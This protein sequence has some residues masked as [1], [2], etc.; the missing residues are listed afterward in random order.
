VEAAGSIAC[1]VTKRAKP[2]RT[3][4]VLGIGLA[5]LG[6]ILYSAST[7]DRRPPTVL[8]TTLTQHLSGDP[9]MALTTSSI[10]V[11]FSEPID[12]PTG[13]AAFE[14][15][16]RVTGS[17]SWSAARLI[18]TPAARLPLKTDFV[19]SIGPGVRD[20]A[21]NL[22]ATGRAPFE[23]TTVGNPLVLKSD[24]ANNVDDVPL[25][26][27]ITIDF[28]T[29]MD[30]PSVERALSLTPD[31]AVA[32][33]W[34]RERLTIVPAAPL[35]PNRRYTLTIGIGAHDQA[36]TPLE[37]QFQLTFRTVP[38]GLTARGLIPADGVAGIAVTTPIAVVL[39]RAI[40]PSSVRDDLLTITPA[41][42]GSLAAIA[43][44]G[45]AG[46]SDGSVHVLRFQPSGPLDPNTTY[47]VALKPGLL[48]TDGAAMPAGLSWTF[49]TGAPTGT[50]SNQ[51]VFVSDR[52]GI[53]NLWAMNPDGTNQRQLS[54]ELSPVVDY[55][56]A[57]DGRAFLVADGATIIWERAD[58]SA[59]RLLTDT[60]V[61]EFDPAF[62]PDGSSITFGRADPVLGGGLGLWSRDADGSDPRRVELPKGAEPTPSAGQAAPQPLLRAPRISPDGTALAFIDGA[63]RIAIL[64]LKLRQL[65]TAPF[66]ALSEPTWLPDSGGVLVS[67]LPIGTG[68]APIAYQPRSAVALLDP[69]SGNLLPAQLAAVEVVRLDRSSTSVVATTFGAGAAR[70]TLDASGRYA[71]IRLGGP[72]AMAG[73]LVLTSSLADPGSEVMRDPAARVSSASFAPEPHAMVIARVPASTGDPALT[74][75]VWVVNLTSGLAQQLS[76]DGR[77]PYWL[78]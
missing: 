56:V 45:A 59:R 35:D 11:D 54:A 68:F 9:Q 75:G 43:P 61:I 16:P 27:P 74:G 29:L 57:P 26:V 55:S 23:F 5:V 6:A 42:A 66:V 24:P 50:L 44:P 2:F 14:I 30:T 78:P 40:D 28:S 32:L 38:S 63:G 76:V 37:Q 73:S 53:A 62:S 77:Q 17:F 70:P 18:F 47:E 1:S 15:T 69:V 8:D 10:E 67:G 4:A 12:H 39:D 48:G 21:G 20:V 65:T 13:Q 33:R 60:G 7:D 31:F 36:G 34:S 51:V 3:L 64:D 52:G 72:D 71:F 19:V 22:M 58:G 46:L 41:V 25:N 49:T